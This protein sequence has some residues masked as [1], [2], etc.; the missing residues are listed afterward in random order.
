MDVKRAG[1][2]VLMLVILGSAGFAQDRATLSGRVGASS[3]ASV[4]PAR[5]GRTSVPSASIRISV[6]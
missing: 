1:A 2:V 6:P 4:S 3:L 5:Q